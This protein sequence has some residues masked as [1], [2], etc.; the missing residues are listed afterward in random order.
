MTLVT[1]NIRLADNGIYLSLMK[2]PD[3]VASLERLE[4]LDPLLRRIIRDKLVIAC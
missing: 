2:L 3:S 4:P 1:A